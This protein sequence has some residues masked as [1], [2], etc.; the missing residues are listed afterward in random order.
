MRF[1]IT[2]P[3]YKRTFLAECIESI[4]NQNYSEFELIIVDDD[5]PEDL[6]S[7][8]S[9]YND[10]RIHYYKNKNNCGALHVV[11]NWNKCLEYAIGDYV[12]CM[13]DDDKLLPGCLEEYDKL[14]KKY[15]NLNIYHGWTEIINEESIITN[16]TAPRPEYESVFS[17]IYNRWFQREQYI[18]DFLFQRSALINEGGF[19]DLPYA[20]CSDDITAVRAAYPNGIANTQV[21]VFQ[22]RV[23]SQT[24]SRGGDEEKKYEA[25]ISAREW[26]D[27]FLKNDVGKDDLSE[28][29]RM[30]SIS[31]MDTYFQL[32]Y[33]DTIY[34]D[35]Q[36]HSIPGCF[37][38]FR[39]RN[40][41]NISI[42]SIISIFFR[43]LK[44]R[45]I[46]K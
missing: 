33:K 45:I 36:K 28:K 14:I 1:S 34:K 21:P 26:F 42:L 38:W 13:G 35:I 12:I 7:I 29:Y 25:L 24:I 20:W 3:A 43:I 41:Y 4:L 15:P 40:Q 6:D 46:K 9:Q 16:I 5:S 39:K 19:Y 27:S 18:G 8:V 44:E 11:D 2:I 10:D 37:K 30:L 23:N 32:R 17:L 22:Y 31:K